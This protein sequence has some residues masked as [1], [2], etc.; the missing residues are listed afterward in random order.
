MVIGYILPTLHIQV[1]CKN[2]CLN[3]E[4]VEKNFKTVVQLCVRN[5]NLITGVAIENLYRVKNLYSRPCLLPFFL[6]FSIADEASTEVTEVEVISVGK[7]N[8]T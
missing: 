6:P 5:G 4:R 1:T 8:H 2:E 7:P 3:I